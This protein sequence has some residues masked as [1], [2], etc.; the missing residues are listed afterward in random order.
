[1][2]LP[3]RERAAA[4]DAL[5]A[6]DPRMAARLAPELVYRV[7]DVVYG[8]RCEYAC[9]LSDLLMR[10]THVAFERRDAGIA[11]APLVADAV[12]P[13][14]GWD[15]TSRELAVETYARDARRVFGRDNG[16]YS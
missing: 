11:L 14:L 2:P 6:S 3:G 1:V 4:V 10:R 13:L 16:A 7:A 8:V 12:A 5:A 9:T 15:A